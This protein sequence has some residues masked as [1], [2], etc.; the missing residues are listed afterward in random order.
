MIDLARIRSDIT[1]GSEDARFLAFMELYASR[2]PDAQVEVDR[3]IQL[4]DPLVKLMFTRFLGRIDEERAVRYLCWMMED[5]NAVVVEAAQRS[6]ERNRFEKKMDVLQYLLGSTHRNAL[7]YAI[8][9]L[10]QAGQVHILDRLLDMIPGADEPLLDALLMAMRYMPS[11]KGVETLLRLRTD[12]RP[13]VRFRVALACCSY[14]QAGIHRLHSCLVDFLGDADPNVRQTAVWGISQ[15]LQHHDVGHLMRVSTADADATV[16]Q[17]AI[18]AL[19]KFPSRAVVEHLLKVLVAEP[20]KWVAMRCESILLNMPVK[21]LQKGMGH[22]LKGPTG[23]LR[24]RAILLSAEVLRGS[25]DY[26]EYLLCGVEAADTDKLRMSYLEALGVY[27]DPRAVPV[28]LKYLK[29]S[30]LLGYVAMGALIKVA[31]TD[32]PLVDFLEDPAGAPILKQ[33]VLRHF[34]R[35]EKIAPEF[36]ERLV[37][38]LYGFLK[39]DTINIRYLGAQV[40]VHLSGASVQDAILE[41]MQMETDPASFELMRTNLLRFFTKS[42]PVFAEALRRNRNN[43]QAFAMLQEVMPDIIWTAEDIAGQVPCILDDAVVRDDPAYVAHCAQWIGRQL[44]LGRVSLDQVL[45]G[46]GGLKCEGLVLARLVDQLRQYPHLRLPVTGEALRS[47]A[48]TGDEAMRRA[49]IELMGIARDAGVVPA[50]VDVICDEGMAPLH[51]VAHQSLT[52]I[53]GDPA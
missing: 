17:A 6:F 36:H 35:V 10:S 23:L 48:G 31:P 50:L 46:L 32:E 43:D 52:R 15:L 45:G 4:R 33:M 25:E 19:G 28:L 29:S 11:R 24:N 44:F 20:D 18:T 5:D 51:A 27:G 2:D 13:H 9:Q 12:P 16:R 3:I 47:R 7:L 42:P 22:A 37:R 26:Y 1:T 39:S 21:L 30:P 49:L 8:D 38:A 40:L 53:M 14:C 34:S 41:T